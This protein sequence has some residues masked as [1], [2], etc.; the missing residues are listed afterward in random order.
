[1]VV[2]LSPFAVFLMLLF[3]RTT[4]WHQPPSS[5]SSVAQRR[6]PRRT[7]GVV[8]RTRRMGPRAAA[9]P[10]DKDTKT[11][12]PP[13]TKQGMMECEGDNGGDANDDDDD[14]DISSDPVG[15]V[16]NMD[17]A[18]K[19]LSETGEW[20]VEKFN[21]PWFDETVEVDAR[22]RQKQE[23]ERAAVEAAGQS[24]SVF[25]AASS[26]FGAVYSWAKR[27]VERDPELASALF[28]GLYIGFLLFV[29]KSMV[30]NY[31]ET[32]WNPA[33]GRLF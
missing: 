16:A 6:L 14:D 33:H 15:A 1:M 4:A 13:P 8:I 32:V 17:S 10:D 12:E 22:L 11:L 18:Q 5:L 19:K 28:I 30:V 20:L 24:G 23:E 2:A 27:Q 7:C 3:W 31:K 9:S 29:A 21:E 25:R 26:S